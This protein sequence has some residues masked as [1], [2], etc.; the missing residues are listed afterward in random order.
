MF[1]HTFEYGYVYDIKFTNNGEVNLTI[2]HGYMCF[3]SEFFGLM[4][5]IKN[6]QKDGFRFNEIVKLTIK[7]NS[8]QSHL[9]IY[10]YLKLPIPIMHKEFFKILSRK[11]EYVKTLCN[12]SNTFFAC[13]KWIITQ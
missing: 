2:T 8:R 6:A 12:D 13:R 3:R 4:R 7:N 5:K 9:N 1:F 11:P 10:F